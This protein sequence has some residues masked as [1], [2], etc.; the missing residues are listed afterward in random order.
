MA[1]V[2]SAGAVVVAVLGAACS[3]PAG[4]QPFASANPAAGEASVVDP[5]A[6]HALSVVSLAPGIGWA[7]LSYQATLVVQSR[8]PVT[9]DNISVGVQDASG[10]R[11]DFPGMHAATVDGVYVFTSLPRS[12][13]PGNYAEFGTYEIRNVWYRLPVHA[14]RVLAGPSLRV[15]NPGPV[16]IPGRWVSTLN[17]GPGYQHGAV[18]DT[19]SALMSWNGASGHA[20][21]PNNTYEQTCY[22]PANVRLQGRLVGLSLTQ[23]DTSRCNVPPGYVPEPFY[24]A[25]ISTH[26]AQFISPGS[27]VE[28]EIYLPPTAD[29]QIADWPA[30]WLSGTIRDWPTTGEIDIVEGL[31][32]QG[33]YHFNWGTVAQT[34]SRGRCPSLGPGWHIFGLDWQPADARSAAASKGAQVSYRMTYYYDG[35]AVGTIV[36]NGVV[37]QPLALL[38][39]ITDKDAAPSLLPATMQVAYVRAWAG[40]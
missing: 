37:K 24:G 40:S 18:N 38:L 11:Y 17:A 25:Q 10:V 28:A 13:S 19:V 30:F 27:A 21:E 35:Q 26:A 15:P 1:A 16:G 2:V 32:G 29:G 22:A 3:A 34:L 9:V 31:D 6:A 36:Q 20:A 14:L 39:D 7:G 5:Q 8:Q 23:P 12:F 33:C 4:R